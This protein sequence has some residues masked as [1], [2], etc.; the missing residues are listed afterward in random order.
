[1]FVYSGLSIGDAR[2]KSFKSQL[3]NLA[4]LWSS[5]IVLSARIFNST[6]YVLGAPVSSTNSNL[7]PPTIN[8]IRNCSFCK[9]QKPAT[10]FAYVT[11]AMEG[12]SD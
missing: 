1:M 12:T 5:E 11:F 7:S 3:K 6:I 2:K 9:D 8:L 10:K 4:P